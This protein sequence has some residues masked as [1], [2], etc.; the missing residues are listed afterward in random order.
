MMN[1]ALVR[2]WKSGWLLAAVTMTVAARVAFAAAPADAGDDRAH[3][4]VAGALNK[5]D[6]AVAAIV[7]VPA[8]QRTF[9]N[10]F[11]AYDDLTT[12]LQTDTNM[13]AFMANVSPDKDKRDAGNQAQEDV[14]N[15]GVQLLKREDLYAALKAVAQSK[16][17]VTAEQQRLMDYVMRDFCRRTSAINSRRSNW[18][19]T[20]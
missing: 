5:A 11:L 16:P 19:S 14:A 2:V 10:T 20:N 17:K 18:N 8:D 9:T 12:R 1:E 3:S 4:P 7:A 13:I 15:Y 6:A